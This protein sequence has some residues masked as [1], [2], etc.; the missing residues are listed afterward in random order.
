MI[1]FFNKI[2]YVLK[3]SNIFILFFDLQKCWNEFGKSFVKSTLR[4]ESQ[5]I[6]PELWLQLIILRPTIRFGSLKVSLRS[7]FIRLEINANI[8]LY[9]H[10]KRQQN[11]HRN[12]TLG[13]TIASPRPLF[14][15]LW[16][17]PQR[18]A[19]IQVLHQNLAF[20]QLHQC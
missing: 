10:Y 9:P 1:L 8:L 11:Q 17:T 5:E 7:Q 3:P 12:S 6:I 15:L 2:F 18:L 4:H 19:N 20:L 13:E 14:G 16:R